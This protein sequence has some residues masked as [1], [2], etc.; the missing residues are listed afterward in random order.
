[1]NT[2]EINA[3]NINVMMNLSIIYYVSY[4]ELT[5]YICTL[6][7]DKLIHYIYYLQSHES[8][9]YNM[10]LQPYGELIHYI[11]YMYL[12][13]HEVIHYLYHISI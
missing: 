11:L 6:P 4:E 3:K 10:Y 2:V 1:M 8:I 12:L 7:Y 9:A 5:H 13:F